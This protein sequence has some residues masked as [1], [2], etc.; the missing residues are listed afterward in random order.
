M[1]HDKTTWHSLSRVQTRLIVYQ[2]NLVNNDPKRGIRPTDL[3]CFSEAP[4]EGMNE[5][6]QSQRANEEE[7]THL[8]CENTSLAF[9]LPQTHDTFVEELDT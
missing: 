9:M 8:I 1:L 5:P 6:S 4:G 3:K 2:G 7:T